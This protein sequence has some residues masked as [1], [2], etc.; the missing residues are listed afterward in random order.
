[1]PHG[2]IPVTVTQPVFYDAEGTHLH[3]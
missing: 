1:M 3:A 2:D